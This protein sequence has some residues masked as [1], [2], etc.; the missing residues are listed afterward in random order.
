MVPRVLLKTHNGAIHSGFH[1]VEAVF[2]HS[3]SATCSFI[4]CPLK[5]ALKNATRISEVSVLN[6]INSKH[7]LQLSTILHY[8]LT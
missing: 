7:T 8:Q 4:F 1:A 6:A 5:N 2:T 3:P